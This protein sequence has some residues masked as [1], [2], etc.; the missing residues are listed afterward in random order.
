[1]TGIISG[2][3]SNVAA[4][5][6]LGG[7]TW[8]LSNA[9]NTY[10][11]ET[12]VSGGKLV[13]DG[14]ISTSVLTNVNDTAT[15]GGI[16]TTGAVTVLNGGTLAP[17]SSAGTLTVSGALTLN[18]LSKLAFELNPTDYAIG[19]G[20][21]DLIIGVNGLTLDGLLTVT[22]TSGSFASVTSGTWRLMNYSGTFTN[23]T[24]AFDS[25][26]ALASGYS[27]ALDTSTAGQV[28]ITVIPEAHAALLGGI[29]MLLLLRRRR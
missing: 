2:S 29:G 10:T 26:P 4:L 28:N 9:N 22:A 25:M 11:G 1:M 27:W 17:G 14:N 5:T 20:F 7:G 19:S 13:V 15:L 6:K 3:G 21:N 8:T 18:S 24:L 23:N 16:G 12:T